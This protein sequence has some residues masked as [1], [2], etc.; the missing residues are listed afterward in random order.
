MLA[1]TMGC[2]NV[3]RWAA[4]GAAAG[5]AVGG[6]W[7]SHAMGALSQ[8]HAA[9][10]G[11][12][13]GGLAGALIG[14]MLDED[15]PGA[16]PDE[17]AR[18]QEEN[19]SLRAQLQAKDQELANA[20][21]RIKELEDELARYKGKTAMEIVYSFPADVLFRSGSAR[22][23]S[24]GRQLLDDAA[25]KLQQQSGNLIMIE[26]HTDSQPIRYSKWKSNWELG[27]ARS[28]TVLHYLESK[29]VD[30]AKMSA[31]TFSEY[32]PVADN[33]SADGRRQNRRADIVVYSN[34]RPASGGGGGG[35]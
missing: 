19:R 10:V 28:L 3:Q 33:G 31:S 34:W 30:A 4:G 2:T 29:G 18:L 9:L 1:A 13:V 26:G 27:A 7:A 21:R 25:Q 20:M 22:L 15:E 11:A 6:I 14:D 23:S 35:Q 8:G 16:D 32:H 17:L 24:E 12:S 5:A